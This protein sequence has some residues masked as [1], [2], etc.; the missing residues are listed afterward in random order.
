MTEADSSALP[1]WRAIPRALFKKL[2]K[3]KISILAAGVAFFS[4]LS[5]FPALSALV[6]LIGLLVD[7]GFVRAQLANLQG[8]M[9]SEAI[10]LLSTWLDTLLQRSRSTFGL[11]LLISVAI[12]VWI[13]RRA[14]SAMITALN[15]A[16]EEAEARTFVLYNLVALSLTAMLMLF[17]AIA[18]LLVAV[19]PVMVELLPVPTSIASL[20]PLLRWPA[21]AVLTAIAI[22]FLYRFGPNRPHSRWE[23]VSAGAVLA[24]LLWIIGSIGLSIYVSRFA[25][26]DRTY[27]SIGAVVVL[28]LWLWLGAYAV[29]AGAALNSIVAKRTYGDSSAD[30]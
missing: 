20:F 11:N 13:A 9:P 2:T 18:L 19:L 28:L 8:A 1:W 29:L 15:V 30:A 14:T 25:D 26:F 12:S 3:D 22:A 5:I 17:G 21:L 10:S 6:S 24:T 4:L 23:W 16:Y 27:G 7:P